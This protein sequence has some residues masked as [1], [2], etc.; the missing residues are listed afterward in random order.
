MSYKRSLLDTKGSLT[1][2]AIRAGYSNFFI[3]NN[4]KKVKMHGFI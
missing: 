4:N 2:R 1:P 3:N